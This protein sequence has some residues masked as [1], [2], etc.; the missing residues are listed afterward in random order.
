MEYV[1]SYFSR[2]S[3]LP[4]PEG[5]EIE[6]YFGLS[7]LDISDVDNEDDEVLKIQLRLKLYA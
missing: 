5:N 6:R 7:R 3:R 4:F 1:Y 2:S